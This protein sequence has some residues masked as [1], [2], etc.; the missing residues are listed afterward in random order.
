MFKKLKAAI[1][2]SPSAYD[3]AIIPLALYR[4][5]TGVIQRRRGAGGFIGSTLSFMRRSS[6]ITGRPMNVTIE[7]TT[8]C[9]LH[10]PVCETG[11]G[12]LP[13]P[14][15]NMSLEEFKTIIDKISAHTNTLMFYFAGE[16]FLNKDS[17]DMIRYAKDKGIPF[18]DSCTNGDMVN[19]ERLVECGIDEVYFQ[20][21]GMTQETHQTYRIGSNLKRVLNN[22]KETVRIRNERRQ[23]M[24]IKSGFILM[25]H[26]EHEVEKFKAEMLEIGVDYAAVID[27]CVN[28][29]EQG[30]ELLPTDKAHWIYDIKAFDNGVLKPKE[31]LGFRCPWIYYSCAILVNGDV[32]P[33][34]RDANGDF[35]MGNI[36]AQEFDEIWN[37]ERYRAFRDKINHNRDKMSLCR[38]CSGYGVCL[39]K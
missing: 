1:K 13:R 4:G 36:L 21:G 19:P 29:I 22:L 7:P 8:I 12:I 17:Y 6:Y 10:C 26:N 38:L 24:S 20:I 31:F 23:K 35:V 9:N 25:K 30:K 5:L 2:G 33:C 18:I 16:S 3:S 39:I 11:S 37:G 14:K 15:Q 34:C 27:P 28:T 32:V